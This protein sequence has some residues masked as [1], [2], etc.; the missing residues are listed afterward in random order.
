MTRNYPLTALRTFEAAGRHLSFIE[1]ASELS[2]TPAAVSQ[3]V[4]RLEAY[5]ETPLF[6]RLP[7]GLLLTDA[8]QALLQD[9]RPV[10]V[11]LDGAIEKV[12][13]QQA[14]GALTISVAP[15]FATKWLLPRLDQFHE[16][17]PLIDL[18]IS[19]SLNLI[20]FSRDSFDA[21]VRLGDGN[22][23]GLCAIK[24]FDEAVVPMCSPVLLER[25]G[26]QADHEALHQVVLLHNDSTAFDPNSPDWEGWL[27]AAQLS[28][29]DATR[30]PRFQQPDH[31]IQAAIDGAGA[32]LG[33]RSL[34]QAD[35]EAGR[36]VCLSNLDISL[37]SSFYLVY[38]EAFESRP[39]VKVL[40]EW[41]SAQQ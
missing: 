36:L 4:K 28:D 32:V 27:K 21:A 33:W 9:L 26:L 34:V 13:E 29:V 18:R 5:L 41:L 31:A 30:G 15:M 7:R 11:A 17:H 16:A 12:K 37:S 8:G 39:K 10:F 35:V 14:T 1:A 38:P 6:Q 25:L 19:S 40:R 24:L 2:V 22:Y 23:P 20:D 3:Q